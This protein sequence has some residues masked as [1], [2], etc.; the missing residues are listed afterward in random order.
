MIGQTTSNLQDIREAQKKLLEL[1][2]NYWIDDVLFSFNW[3]FLILLTLMPWLL[4]YRFVDK[5]RIMEIVLMGIL[6]IITTVIY[7]ILGVSFLLW[8]YN[9]N[10]IQMV[11]FHITIDFAIVPIGYMLVYQLFQHW[12]SYIFALAIV[13]A[14][15]SF[16]VEPLFV[17]MGIYKVISWKHIYSFFAYFIMGIIMKFLVRKIIDKQVKA[18][19]NF[20]E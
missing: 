16:V 17:W 3:W 12:K 10:V 6:I 18:N 14:V 19:T 1:N 8:S 4:W 13:A 20:L 11:P 9:Y 7:D 15:A 5:K 2:Y